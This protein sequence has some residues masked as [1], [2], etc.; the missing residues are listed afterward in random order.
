MRGVG[1]GSNWALKP[2]GSPAPVALL[3]TV[4][5]AAVLGYMLIMVIFQ[6]MHFS[7]LVCLSSWSLH[8]SSG[9]T[10]PP[11]IILHGG[12]AGAITL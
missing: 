11:G 12:P 1:E 5:M 2:L 9:T 3:V 7:L 4:H 6:G 10:N 8:L